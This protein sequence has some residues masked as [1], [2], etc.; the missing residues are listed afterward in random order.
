MEQYEI[1]G[2]LH[3]MHFMLQGI[4]L[5]LDLNVVKKVIPLAFIEKVPKSLKYVVGVI[6]LAGKSVSVIDLALRLDL[7]RKNMYSL[8]TP[9]ILCQNE[10]C[11]TGI[12]VDKILG[13]NLIKK[14]L[15]QTNKNYLSE[16]SP[17]LG[18]I[19]INGDLI[20]MLDTSK[21]LNKNVVINNSAIIRQATQEG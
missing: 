7:N 16:H 10:L 17:I 3:I 18:V 14:N 4:Q 2:K 13:I 20:L 11:E 21:I 15:L 9:I 5:C 12:V 8:D 6:N 19:H 1:S